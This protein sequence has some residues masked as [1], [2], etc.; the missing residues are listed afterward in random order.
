MK[1]FI[2]PLSM[3][4][5]SSM[6]FAQNAND[7]LIKVG[8]ETITKSQF[9]TAY[10]KN[11]LLSE[12]TEKDLREYLDLYIN[13]RMKVQE[14]IKLQ[15]DTSTAFKKE[16]ASYE[17]QSAQQYLIDTEVSEQLLEEAF[18]RSKYQVRA[19]HI[20]IRCNPN[21]SPKDTLAA[22]HKIQQI[23]EKIV[24]GLDFN[25]AAY[26]YSEDESAQDHVNPQSKRMQYGN[27]GE[28][29]YFSVL[30]M[31]YPFEVAAYT[32]PV[33]QVSQPFRTQFG[34]HLVYVQ[35]KIPAIAKL[36]VSQIFIADTN[37]LKNSKPAP[38]IQDKLNN[39]INEYKNGKSF[40]ELAKLF[41]EDKA[42]KDNGGQMTAFTPNRRPGN[43]V[44]A[45]INLKGDEITEPVP[46]SIG[47]HIMKLDSVKYAIANEE[48]K[49]MLKSKLQRDPRSRKSKESLV[50]KLK[51]EYNF[52]ES[53]KAAAM[54]FFKKNVPASYF[55]STAVAIDSIK[56]IEKL[57]PIFTFAGQEVSA[58][59][60]AK[61]I[62][63][64]QGAPLNVS[65]I[66]FIESLYPN[67]VSEQ[68]LRYERRHLT[69]KYPEYKE[70]VTEFHDGMLLYEINSEKVWN[71]AIKDS[72]GLEKFYESVKTEYPA[73]NPSDSIQY[74]PLSEIRAI[75]VS[76][77]QD[78]LEQAWLKELHEKYPVVV[79][80]KVFK[81]ILK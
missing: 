44:S 51:K 80:E 18:D 14:A 45:I 3:L 1:R 75:I 46:S 48:T 64:Y 40:A 13:Y 33:G 56:G 69:E 58:I 25:E 36:N 21:A 47:W 6:A 34:Y 61:F 37:A 77:F 57:K 79:D 38:E 4:L 68:M 11:N 66:Q 16:L 54:K 20:L 22:L 53:G 19:S 35:D 42:T 62:S 26:L 49:F 76:R 28:L 78:S 60:F 7:I 70:L 27:K 71:A 29:G 10:Q 24:N 59:E 65:P 55:Q 41:S 2:L 31:I 43:Y 39:I 5:L 30:E 74:K 81:T 50:E 72:I 63:R 15:M 17:G 32:N 8:N 67:F 73:E 23:R 9:V 12:S 52:Q